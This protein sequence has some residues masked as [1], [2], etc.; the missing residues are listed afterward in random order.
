MIIVMTPRNDSNLL[1][2]IYISVYQ[3]CI[4]SILMIDIY[5]EDLIQIIIAVFHVLLINRY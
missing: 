1:E 2:N 3:T 5:F 4:V